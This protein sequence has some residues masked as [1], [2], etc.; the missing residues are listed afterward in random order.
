[1]NE[2]AFS[3]MFEYE[4]EWDWE[5]DWEL[6]Y[7]I[8]FLFWKDD[9]EEIWNYKTII[10]II[11]FTSPSFWI[12]KFITHSAKK[13]PKVDFVWFDFHKECKNMKYENLSKLEEITAERVVNGE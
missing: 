1:M 6:L 5:W 9:S 10:I 13:T 4:Y 3:S 11:M 12:T 8:I 2:L 7:I